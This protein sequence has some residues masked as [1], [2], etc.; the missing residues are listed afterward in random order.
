MNS[1]NKNKKNELKEITKEF[2]KDDTLSVAKKL[3][4][5][6]ICKDDICARITEVEAYKEDKASHAYKKTKRSELMRETYGKVYVYLIYG[7]YYCLNFTTDTTPGAVLI[8]ALDANG[9]EGPGKLCKTLSIT[10]DDNAKDVGCKIKI[11]EDEYKPRIK[12]YERIGIREDTHLKWRFIDEKLKIE[13]KKKKT[14]QN[15]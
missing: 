11:F 14:S 2:F 8:R 3:V 13:K 15:K 12:R 9:C 7:M 10:K 1:N 4:G 5:K 6:I